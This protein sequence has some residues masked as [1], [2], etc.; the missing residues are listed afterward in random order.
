[1]IIKKVKKHKPNE[2]TTM[3]TTTKTELQTILS[4][5]STYS[6]GR[7]DRINKASQVLTYIAWQEYP[8]E[9]FTTLVED[10]KNIYPGDEYPEELEQLPNVV[11]DKGIEFT[12]L[13]NDKTRGSEFYC[14]GIQVDTEEWYSEL[15]KLI[16]QKLENN[17]EIWEQVQ[18]AISEFNVNLS[19]EIKENLQRKGITDVDLDALS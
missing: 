8:S 4:N 13:W 17:D 7:Y 16:I 2:V 3:T 19:Q 12:V 18:N 15:P 1:V 11:F 5:L 6:G 14:D 10:L 9:S